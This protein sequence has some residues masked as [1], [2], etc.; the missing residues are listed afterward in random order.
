MTSFYVSSQVSDVIND[1]SLLNTERFL[2]LWGFSLVLYDPRDTV[3]GET[4]IRPEVS[5]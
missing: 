1:T 4:V 5:G 2:L 3:Y